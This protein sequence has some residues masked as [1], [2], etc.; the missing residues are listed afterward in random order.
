LP[1]AYSR[2]ATHAVAAQWQWWSMMKSIGKIASTMDQI[3]DDMLVK[4]ARVNEVSEGTLSSLMAP[5]LVEVGFALPLCEDAAMF[6]SPLVEKV[7]A[8]L[9]RAHAHMH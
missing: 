7:D 1:R 6:F 8:I 5:R 4:L 9:R 2:F 3:T